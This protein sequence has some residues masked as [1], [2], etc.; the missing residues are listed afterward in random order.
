MEHGRCCR[1]ERDRHGIGARIL[2]AF[3]KIF[4]KKSSASKWVDSQ[5][6]HIT[7]NEQVDQDDTDVHDRSSDRQP[8]RVYIEG[9]YEDISLTSDATKALYDKQLIDVSILPVSDIQRSY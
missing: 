5:P 8:V 4:S 3:T 2:R 1:C 7:A 9:I 6:P